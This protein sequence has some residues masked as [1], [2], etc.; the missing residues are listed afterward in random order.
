MVGDV[1]VA[2]V[3]GLVQGVVEWL[4]VSSEGTVAVVLTLLGR[5]PEAA[6]QLALFLHVGTATSA[7]T[8]YRGEVAALA[9]SLS[10]WRPGDDRTGETATLVFLAVATGSSGVVALAAYAGLR[11]LVSELTGAAFVSLVGALLVATGVVLRT[12]EGVTLGE[13]TDPDLLDALLVGV[14]QGLAVLP[15]V[16]R[17]GTTVSALLLRGHPAE[18]ALRLSFLLSVPASL[19][20]GVLVVVETGGAPT[21]SPLAAAVALGTAAV[22]GYVTVD[23]LVRVVR[24]VAFWVV[25]VGLGS[26][27]VVAG[28]LVALG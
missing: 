6:V 21:V 8:Y 19:G 18:G 24:R 11:A 5:E 12:A 15:G 1:V 9:R 27:A 17:S 4:P 26:L 3:V 2:L 7:V 14:L 10:Q 25:C 20:A 23:A 28:A 16:S 22:W 13:R